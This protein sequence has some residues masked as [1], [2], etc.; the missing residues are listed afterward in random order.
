[1]DLVIY[2]F[3]WKKVSYNAMKIYDEIEK[4]YNKVWIINCDENITMNKKNVIQA[5]DTYYFGK[6]FY[7]CL[8]HLRNN[9]N[10]NHTFMN[11]TGDVNP[12]ANW[13][14]IIERIK[15]GF[16]N[17]NCGVVAPNVEYTAHHQKYE[18]FKENYWFVKNTDCTAWAIHP[19]VIKFLEEANLLNFS[20]YG[21]GIDWIS[22]EFCKKNGM[23]VLRDYDNI[24]YQ[25]KGTA[26]PSKKADLEFRR[27]KLLWYGKYAKV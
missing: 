6:Q 7:T 25:P 4:V 13:K 2:I 27:V 20:F 14:S 24:V 22:I 12:N 15:Y 5:N 26:Y 23:L 10:E 11:I 21:W 19:R 8:K 18:E 1:M 9:Y 16:D 3:S 17:L